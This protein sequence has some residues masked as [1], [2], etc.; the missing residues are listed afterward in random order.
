MLTLEVEFRFQG[1]VGVTGST[2]NTFGGFRKISA[3]KPQL[4]QNLKKR[5]GKTQ[6]TDYCAPGTIAA[7][8][9]HLPKSRPRKHTQLSADSTPFQDACNEQHNSTPTARVTEA[10]AELLD[11]GISIS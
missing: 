8:S 9:G 3:T 5:V 10:F 2:S 7:R 4:Q 6:N 11:N 1:V